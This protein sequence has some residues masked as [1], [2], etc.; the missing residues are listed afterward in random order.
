[1]EGVYQFG[2]ISHI[3]LRQDPSV[4]RSVSFPKAA[5]SVLSGQLDSL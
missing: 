5:P 2:L 3:I 1:M 4:L